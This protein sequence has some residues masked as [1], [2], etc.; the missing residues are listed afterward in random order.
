MRDVR[1]AVHEV[2]AIQHDILKSSSSQKAGSDQ[3]SIDQIAIQIEKL[4]AIND[5][6]DSGIESHTK[7]K[8]TPSPDIV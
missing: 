6:R 4:P 2:K 8:E 1:D 3:A 7:R 5:K